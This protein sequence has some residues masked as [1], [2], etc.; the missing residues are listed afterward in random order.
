MCCAGGKRDQSGAGSSAQISGFICADPGILARLNHERLPRPWPP[1]PQPPPTTP[2]TRSAWPNSWKTVS[3]SPNTPTTSNHPNHLQCVAELVEQRLHLA[4]GHEAGLPSDG[5]RLVAHHVCH[6]QAHAGAGGGQQLG[7]ADH[8]SHPGATALLGGP[9]GKGR[10][11]MGRA[12]RGGNGW[13]GDELGREVLDDSRCAP[14]VR[15]MHQV[16]A[17]P[18]PHTCCTE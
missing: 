8:L 9:V 2:T 12:A 3:T 4:E 15:S 14:S 13:G 16:A 18:H 10:E 7:A 5:R 11:G 17:V 6:R 1:Q